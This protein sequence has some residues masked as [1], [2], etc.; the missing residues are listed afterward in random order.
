M[1]LDPRQYDFPVALQILGDR[2]K[3]QFILRD[4]L[5]HDLA[6]EPLYLMQ[7]FI[8]VSI[9]PTLIGMPKMKAHMM[10][11]GKPYASAL[12]SSGSSQSK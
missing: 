11:S 4:F 1:L 3:R 9:R 5:Q 12:G 2:P 10:A 6:A 8:L 7:R